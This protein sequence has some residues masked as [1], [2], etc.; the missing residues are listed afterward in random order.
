MITRGLG[1]NQKLITRGM[2]SKVVTVISREVLRLKSAII[3]AVSFG[4]SLAKHIAI[5]SALWR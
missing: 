4:S 1:K 2:G 3:K 5:R